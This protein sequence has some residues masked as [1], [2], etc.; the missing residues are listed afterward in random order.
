MC[1]YLPPAPG[2]SP[3][4]LAFCLLVK[5]GNG[6]LRVLDNIE[7]QHTIEQARTRARRSKKEKQTNNKH[8]HTQ[9]ARIWHLKEVL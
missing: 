3:E 6:I 9:A 5:R 4:F 1:Y 8:T 2:W 7:P